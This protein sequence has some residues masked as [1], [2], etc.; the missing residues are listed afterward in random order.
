MKFT[1]I[2]VQG[3]RS[4]V[5]V[6]LPLRPLAVM[7]GPN[8][9]GKTALLEVFLLLNRAAWS[10]L[11][12]TLEGYGGLDA[13]LSKV[14]GAS[15]SLKIGL[16]VDVESE[17]SQEP[18]HYHFELVPR[19]FG[20]EIPVEWLEWRL[21]VTAGEPHRYIDAQYHDVRYDDPD[22]PSLLRIT[23]KFDALELALVQV[24]PQIYGEMGK[25]RIALY[26]VKFYSFL[27]VSAR[28]VV[29]LPQSL[30]PA[31][32]PGPNGENL[33]SALYNLR[34]LHQD[35]YTR[36]ED[37]LRVGFPGFERLEFPTVGAGQVTLAWYQGNLTVPLYPNQLSEGT[38]RFLWLTTVLL[39]PDP[40][41]VILID[42]PEVS[43]HPEL[44]K[45]LAGL[46]QDAAVRTQ[47]IV[48]THSPDLVRWLQ[49]QEVLVLDKIVGRTQFT[50]ADT[51]DLKE[52]LEEYTLRDLWLMGTL[53]GRP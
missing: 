22:D 33:Y 26:M 34:A 27:D 44:V 16:A 30:T 46:L 24:P 53:G 50:W 2:Q 21:D 49:P 51:M 45:L 35:V 20:Y 19:G 7:I 29:R 1:E 48:A 17:R 15:N 9:S 13:I 37:V 14:P 12:K 28:S 31:A 41:P 6:S 43:L 3:Y 47:V 25:L 5:D 10:N 39:A 38:L 23:Q 42:E 18:M 52:W 36:I 8:N 4:I 11:A 40:P 32:R